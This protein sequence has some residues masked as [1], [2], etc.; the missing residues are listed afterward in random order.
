MSPRVRTTILALS[1]LI[2]AILLILAAVQVAQPGPWRTAVYLVGGGLFVAIVAT[3]LIGAASGGETQFQWPLM[4][5][6]MTAAGLIVAGVASVTPDGPPRQFVLLAGAGA[7]L[8]LLGWWFFSDGSPAMFRSKDG[9]ETKQDRDT[10]WTRDTVLTFSYVGMAGLVL[11][12]IRSVVPKGPVEGL[13][14]VLGAG[15]LIAC[16]SLLTGALIGFL[17]GIPRAQTGS[18]PPAPGPSGKEGEGHA[19]KQAAAA[20]ASQAEFDV[21]TN[22][23]QISDWLTKIIVGMGLV[24]LRKM[25]GYFQGLGGYFSHA[26]GTD[27][28]GGESVV[29]ALIVLFLVCGFLLGY[30]LTRLFLTGAFTRALSP[31]DQLREALMATDTGTSTGTGD[32]ASTAN[33]EAIQKI[34]L[35]A[36]RVSPDQLKQQVMALATEYNVTRSSLQPG[37]DRTRKL[38]NI[39]LRMQGLAKQAYGILPDLVAGMSDGEKLAAIAFLQVIPDKSYIPWLAETFD[40]GT[41]F[42]MYHAAVALRNSVNAI[43]KTAHT[44]LAA[45]LTECLKHVPDDEP[46]IK[47]ILTDAQSSLQYLAG[48]PDAAT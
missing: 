22:L 7:A 48:D 24:N 17:F 33:I 11:F 25:P 45:A 40:K 2:A 13:F 42:V 32:G 10:R 16:G 47:K 43:G 5:C 14:Q 29:L 30:L 41:R 9:G 28:Q 36:S 31:A 35:V 4:L 21:N 46:N 34:D 37:R 38:D 20:Q 23:E 8:A 15:T 39:V 6:W 44:E 1:H 12:S 18:K 26:L 3:R 27:V 19:S